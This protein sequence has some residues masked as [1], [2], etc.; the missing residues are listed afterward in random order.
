ML[1]KIHNY[2]K[3]LYKLTLKI[4]TFKFSLFIII[5]QML[6]FSLKCWFSI[7]VG[8]CMYY[9]YGIPNIIIN[10]YDS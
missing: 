10:M 6:K 9:V 2:F 5:N 1:L 3:S 4:K 7:W 8:T